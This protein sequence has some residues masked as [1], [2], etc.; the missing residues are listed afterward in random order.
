MTRLPTPRGDLGASLDDVL[1]RSPD[2]QGAPLDAKPSCPEDAALTLWVL[3]ELSYGGFEGIDDDHE[4]SP[5]LLALRVELEDELEERLRASWPGSPDLDFV[6]GFAG[7][8]EEW[9]GPSIA[10]YV[11]TSADRHQADRLLKVRTVYHLKE[12]DPSTWAIPRLPVAAK[13]ALAELQYDEYGVGDPTRLHSHLFAVGLEA[14]G[15]DPTYGAYL[16]DVPLEVL[17]QNNTVSM[18][19]LQ[20]RLRGAAVGHLAAFESTSSMPSRRL[21]QGLERLGYPP[22]MVA[23][24]TEHV[25][26]DAVHENVAIRNI[27]GALIQAEPQLA[28][29]VWFGA[30]ACLHQ[31]DEVARRLLTEWEEETA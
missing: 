15:L 11:H 20:R 2:P 26:A 6:E 22:E 24:Y 19:G 21:A 5:R 27:C 18:F 10:R 4:R 13:A 30:W 3:H 1:R 29:D 8:L 17:E 28:A 16:D 31:E 25:E 23:Y 14:S 9:E 7:W 12:A